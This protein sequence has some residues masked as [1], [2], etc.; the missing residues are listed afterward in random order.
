MKAAQLALTALLLLGL[1]ACA[2]GPNYNTKEVDTRLSP[3]QL[4]AAPAAH[5]GQRIIWGGVIINTRNQS[6]YTEMEVLSYPLDS[7]Q[8]PDISMGEQGRFLVR[9]PG[10]LEAV[11]YAPGRQIT[12]RGKFD[13]V[14]DGKVGEAA[15]TF[16]MVQSEDVYLWPRDGTAGSSPRVHF[17]VGVIFGH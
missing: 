1:A 15:Y 11:D 14:L 13:K 8:R 10:Y 6:G 4:V 3:A 17:G 5:A 2:S 12:V 16:P 7:V 9:H